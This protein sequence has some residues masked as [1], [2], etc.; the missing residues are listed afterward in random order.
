M[1]ITT[2][3]FFKP[4]LSPTETTW[5]TAE[6]QDLLTV[7]ATTTLITGTTRTWTDRVKRAASSN[8]SLP[9]I[10]TK[11]LKIRPST[12]QTIQDQTVSSMRSSSST[13]ATSTM[14]RRLTFRSQLEVSRCS[15]VTISAPSK[16]RKRWKP[17]DSSPSW[18]KNN[19]SLFKKI[20]TTSNNR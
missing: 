2:L 9:P 17:S 7:K 5:S 13:R 6:T 1:L 10:K 14:C 16:K 15:T 3:T 19:V 12:F 8:T 18:E 11:A 4:M 20:H